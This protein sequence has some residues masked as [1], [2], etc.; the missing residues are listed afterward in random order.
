VDRGDPVKAPGDFCLGIAKQHND[1]GFA[2][3]FLNAAAGALPVSQGLV[4][5][6]HHA[7]LVTDIRLAVW[8]G[9][10]ENTR[11]TVGQ[12]VVDQLMHLIYKFNH[13]RIVEKTG[14]DCQ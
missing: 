2:V 12:S 1:L 13:G 14:A 6:D 7:S 10:G 8:R 5:K 11:A 3:T 9:R 4:I